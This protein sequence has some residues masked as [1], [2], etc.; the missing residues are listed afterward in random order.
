MYVTGTRMPYVWERKQNA[1]E[2]IAGVIRN[3]IIK[4]TVGRAWVKYSG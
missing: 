2:D 4:L 1:V 3:G